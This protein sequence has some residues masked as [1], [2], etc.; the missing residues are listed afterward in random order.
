MTVEEKDRLL[1]R[2]ENFFRDIVVINHLKNL[3][4]LTKIKE[5]NVNPFLI[6]YISIF[7]TGKE[8]AESIARAL[9]YPRILGQS[10]TTS[11]GQNAQTKLISGILEAAGAIV[12]GTDIEFIDK[13]DGRK[14]YCQIKAGPDTLNYDD[15]ETIKGKFKTVKNLARQNNSDLGI[16]DLVVGVL[17][18]TKEQ[19]NKFYQKVNEDYPVFVG[20][21]FW[22]RLTGDKNFYSELIERF[23]KVAKETDTKDVLE[24][25]IKELAKDVQKEWVDKQLK[26][27]L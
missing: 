10:I 6:N 17:Y 15:I 22:E 2:A 5:F 9:V 18:G 25:V 4:K 27:N 11:F 14:K 24:Q 13:I 16:N 19:V 26:N 12:Q 21:E 3:K 23:G 7:L 20:E 1:Y 8:D